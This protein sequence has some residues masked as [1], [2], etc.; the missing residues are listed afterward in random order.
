MHRLAIYHKSARMAF[1]GQRN[2]D[3]EMRKQPCTMSTIGRCNSQIKEG[4]KFILLSSIFD[5]KFHVAD[6][7]V[8]RS[9]WQSQKDLMI[10]IHFE[11]AQEIVKQRSITEGFELIEY[12]HG[13]KQ[14]YKGQAP[15]QE[16][17]AMKQVTKEKADDIESFNKQ[18]DDEKEK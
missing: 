15:T 2:Y 5:D 17:I 1:E 12:P 18:M 4:R 10:K 11:F 7:H 14:V 9:C 3:T 8:C 16:E 13:A 6:F